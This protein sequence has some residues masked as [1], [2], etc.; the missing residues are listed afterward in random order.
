MLLILALAATSLPL[1]DPARA[2]TDDETVWAGVDHTCAITPEGAADR[3]GI[4]T[5]GQSQDRAGPFVTV[6]AGGRHNCA[7][8]IGGDAECWGSN[9]YG[10]A[11]DQ[12]GP[13]TAV[14]AGWL[15]SCALTPEGPR[16]CW[17]RN[18]DG[19]GVNHVGPFVEISAG[20][21]HTC[22]RTATGDLECWGANDLGQLGRRLTIRAP[23]RVPPRTRV[24]IAGRLSSIDPA[25]RTP[26]QV[27]LRFLRPS[28][29]RHARR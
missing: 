3:L 17:G 13:Y 29:S 27:V 16:K 7:L 1:A 2:A 11:T 23:S 22:G 15:H 21:Y 12:T 5:A 28:V 26:N 4:D 18:D 24:E 9:T 25:C 10:E 6:S 14:V 8:T 20:S 19:Q